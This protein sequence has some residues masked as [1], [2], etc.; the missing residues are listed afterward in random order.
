ME[1]DYLNLVD[2]VIRYG[3][4]RIDR[5]KIGALSLFG[6]HLEFD[7]SG[8][9]IPLLTTKKI[10][11][12]N[13]LKELLWII[14]GSTDSK[15]LN[16]IGVKVWNDNGSRQFLD[17]CGFTKRKEG[18]L[19]PIY[20]F[21]WR[22]A[23]AKYIDCDTDYT[24]Q[25][26]D[27]LSRVINTIKTDP[28]S[29]RILINSWNVPQL[30]EMVLPPCHTLVQFFV[31]KKNMLDCQ[32]YQRSADL[33]LGVPYNI[34]F[35]SFLTMVLG[36]WCGLTPGKFIHTFGDV[37]V[38]SNHIEPLKVQLSRNPYPFPKAKFIGDFTLQNLDSQSLEECCDMWCDSFIVEDY[39]TH[40]F[41]KMKM[42]V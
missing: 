32:L 12:K 18:D 17:L 3:D 33:G 9:I 34:A 23:G 29:R 13:I 21:Q 41:I 25:G 8:G 19:G 26:I 4:F 36:R 28:S 1:T 10:M 38:Y 24:G 42:A 20:G 27:Q 2:Q 5:T 30:N 31:R 7:L 15:Q 14:K 22:H 16:N 37:H 39:T 6:K 40:P 35:Y 11:Y